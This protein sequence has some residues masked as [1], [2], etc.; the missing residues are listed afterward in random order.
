M[1]ITDLEPYRP[2]I[3]AFDLTEEQKLELVNTIVTIAEVILD[4]KFRS[5]KRGKRINT[6]SI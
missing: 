5:T 3:D 4:K 2:Y 6:N 1:P